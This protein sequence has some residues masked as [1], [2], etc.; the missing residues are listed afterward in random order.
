MRKLLRNE[1]NE[2]Y[3]DFIFKTNN[4]IE[5][6]SNRI[7]AA[8]KKTQL[9]MRQKRPLEMEDGNKS[10]KEYSIFMNKCSFIQETYG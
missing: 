9:K 4:Y 5:D 10:K 7:I 3:I 1:E 2:E 8:E 6:L